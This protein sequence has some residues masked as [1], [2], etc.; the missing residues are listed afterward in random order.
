MKIQSKTKVKIVAYLWLIAVFVVVCQMALLFQ[1]K[2][3]WV[4]FVN[5]GEQPFYEAATK[6]QAF[7]GTIKADYNLLQQENEQ[8]KLDKKQCI[9]SNNKDIE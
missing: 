3:V 4:G 5:V 1:K 7:N 9:E 2:Y 8:L 6:A